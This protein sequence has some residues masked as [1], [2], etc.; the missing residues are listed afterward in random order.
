MMRFKF[1]GVAVGVLTNTLAIVLMLAVILFLYTNLRRSDADLHSAV[2]R[3]KLL[4]IENTQIEKDFA[5]VLG[6][7]DR[8]FREILRRQGCPEP[9]IEALM[10]GEP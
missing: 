9:R 1:P 5:A 10:R 6:R 4:I 3:N 2:E 8:L 7:R